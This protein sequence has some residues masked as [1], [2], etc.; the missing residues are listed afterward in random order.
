MGLTDEEKQD[1]ILY[2]ME[3]SRAT[4]QEA[5]D[6][7]ALQHWSLAAN[8]LYYAVFYMIIA[9]LL[10]KNITAKSHSGVFGMFS[11]EYIRNGIL[12]EEEGMLYR[13]LFSMRQ[14]GDYD[15]MFDWDRSDILPL[16]PRVEA[17]LQRIQSFIV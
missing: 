1:Y 9:L 7:A 17:L 15:D 6:N 16:I 11:K 4:L 10:K 3:K 12:N 5:K 8:R 13:Q 2:R 14:T